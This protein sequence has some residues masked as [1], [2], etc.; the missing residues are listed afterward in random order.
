M[1]SQKA[2]RYLFIALTSFAVGCSTADQSTTSKPNNPASNNQPDT[3]GYAKLI[4]SL[5]AVADSFNVGEFEFVANRLG[6]LENDIKRL[7]PEDI[8]WSHNTIGLSKFY[9]RDNGTALN[10]FKKAVLNDSTYFEAYN[11]IGHMNLLDGNFSEAILNFKKSILINPDYDV[12]RLNLEIAEKFQ[13][14]ELEWKTLEMLSKA[15]STKSPEQKIEIY[16][17][18]INLAPYYVEI[19]NNLAVAEYKIGEINE[20]FKHLSQAITIDP[21]YAMGYNNIGYLYHEYGLYDEAIKHYLI[22]IKLKSTLPE[23][24]ENL[25][26]TYKTMGEYEKAKMVCETLLNINPNRFFAFQMLKEIR[27]ELKLAEKN[28]SKGN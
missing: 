27:E 25:A 11:N 8:A 16:R 17:Q 24:F 21:T 20:A 14:G 9:L 28:K 3:V 6:S 15:D 4:L 26:Y 18:L 22:A 12:A 10:Y 5:S 1:T 23:A 19:Y 7:K 2:F 13:S